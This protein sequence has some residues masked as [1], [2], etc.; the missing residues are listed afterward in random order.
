MG[1]QRKRVAGNLILGTVALTSLDRQIRIT[2]APL[3]SAGELEPR[4]EELVSPAQPISPLPFLISAY[5][6]A[7]TYG[8]RHARRNI[9]ESLDFKKRIESN[10][11]NH[12]EK[13]AH[14]E[15]G[16]YKYGHFV[17]EA[18]EI[19]K[20]E[21]SGKMSKASSTFEK[22]DRQLK[23]MEAAIDSGMTPMEAVPKILGKMRYFKYARRMKTAI[24]F[25]IGN[26]VATTELISALMWDL[27]YKDQIKMRIYKGHVAPI[28]TQEGVDYNLTSGS[29]TTIDGIDLEPIEYLKRYNRRTQILK[30]RQVFD[31]GD[32]STEAMMRNLESGCEESIFGRIAILKHDKNKFEGFAE[33]DQEANENNRAKEEN[34][35]NRKNAPKWI[36]IAVASVIAVLAAVCTTEKNNIQGETNSATTVNRVVAN[37]NEAT[38]QE[39]NIMRREPYELSQINELIGLGNRYHIHEEREYERNRREIVERIVNSNR[40]AVAIIELAKLAVVER[41]YIEIVKLRSHTQEEVDNLEARYDQLLATATRIIGNLTNQDKQEIIR[42]INL[43]TVNAEVPLQFVL[44]GENGMRLA[45]EIGSQTLGRASEYAVYAAGII[46]PR[47]RNQT[48]DE[49][50]RL[51]PEQQIEIANRVS[52]YETNTPEYQPPVRISPNLVFMEM[53]K[54]TPNENE[55]NRQVILPPERA[56]SNRRFFAVVDAIEANNRAQ[57]GDEFESHICREDGEEFSEI[58]ITPNFARYIETVRLRLRRNELGEEFLVPII[59]SNEIFNPRNGTNTTC[60]REEGYGHPQFNLFRREITQWFDSL[61][62][63]NTPAYRQ[64]RETVEEIRN[65]RR[66]VFASDIEPVQEIR[67]ETTRRINAFRVNNAEETEQVQQPT[68]AG[69]T[70][71]RHRER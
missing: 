46:N 43:S 47:T 29:R 4:R 30:R 37:R 5:A 70:R 50:E 49:V 34:S 65:A 3:V 28:F 21:E 6:I 38:A 42:E 52:D 68:I 16:E 53:P 25:G 14:V 48:L 63:Q 60:L 64:L 27:G 11:K 62:Q 40:P 19:A 33:L 24:D 17:I 2:Q 7:G 51:D 57:Y 67:G 18:Q 59:A 36:T 10:K 35:T 44:F 23:G 39:E 45:I 56:T 31:I 1:I 66:V 8:I 58:G 26:C 9:L 55:R 15:S 20:K 32:L 61:A 54:I 69:G 22:Y 13:I 41:R 12:F 71:L